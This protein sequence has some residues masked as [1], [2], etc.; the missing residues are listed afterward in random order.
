MEPEQTEQLAIEA[1]KHAAAEAR[2][3]QKLAD[4]ARWARDMHRAFKGI[5]GAPNRSERARIALYAFN[6][7]EADE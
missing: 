2:Q 7:N 3:A 5:Q 6:L 1:Q 4:A